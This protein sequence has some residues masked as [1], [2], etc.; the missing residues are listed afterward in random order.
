MHGGYATERE[1]KRNKL[2]RDP[3][4]FFADSRL[5]SVRAFKVLFAPNRL[6]LM[7]ARVIRSFL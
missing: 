2:R 7:N 3:Y 1:R 6:G 5:A 4:R